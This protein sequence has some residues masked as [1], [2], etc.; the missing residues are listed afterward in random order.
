MKVRL[1]HSAY[2]ITYWL[3]ELRLSDSR[4]LSA[5]GETYREAMNSC[6]DKYQRLKQP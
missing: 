4:M 3:A 6:L 1:I 5:Q 2:G